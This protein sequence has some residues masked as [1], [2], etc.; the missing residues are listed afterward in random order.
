MTLAL[1]YERMQEY[2]KARDAYE[3]LLSINPNFVAALNNLACLYTEQLNN[4]D[5]AYE[6]ARKA[7]DL[8][9]QDAAVG[10]TLGWVLYKRG[11]YQQALTLLQESAEKA[12]DSPEIQFH[13]GMTAYMV[14]QTDLAKVALR[15][16]AD[17]DK[18]FPG[19]DESK[20]RLA[21][22]ESGKGASPELSV[23][24]LEAM[25][26]AQPNDVVSQMRLGEAYEKQG[27]PDKAAAAYE[28]AFKINPKLPT[29]AIRLA[30]LY[31][32]PLQ[33]K[34]KA[35]AY[36]KK[37]RELSPS[38]P[39]VAGI[40]GRVAYQSGNFS[41]SYSLLQEAA[42]Q[43]QNDA[44]VLYDLAW[45]AYSL[46]KVNE[47]RDAMQKVVTA[48]GDAPQA[49]DAKKFLALT[50]LDENP[51][52]LMAAEGELQKELQSN[53]EYVPALMDQAAL[54]A[55]RGD[56]K[57]ATE[58]YSNI[59][60]RLP[61]FAP[62]QKRLAALY[63]Q[64]PSKVAAAYDLATKARKTLPDDPELSELLGRLS[65]EKKEY[66]RAIQLLQE[67]ARKRPLDADS[68]FYLGMSQLQASQKAE[69]R[70]VLNQA[71][72]AGLQEPLATEAKRAL[73]DLQR[74]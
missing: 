20:R 47:A 18:D 27:A 1:V 29:A 32:G 36:A 41:W 58:T 44:S 21:S 40:L 13:R 66:P 28:Q 53:P 43:R 16:A 64:D 11:D 17:S 61:D 56:A 26:K 9:G 24:Q 19:K 14:G 25:T 34:E 22:L 10:D 59:L 46:G 50:V 62:A 65:Y 38:D 39:Q 55:Q 52:E 51:K 42:R 60:R 35:L 23:S 73:A 4:L 5:K 71:L 3:K 37:A 68:L 2:P 12:P 48:E 45:A 54:L 7:R 63:A 72:V 57:A 8:Q 30:E 49:A 70:G 67:S 33:N 69:A 6:L 31:A 15:K 74:E